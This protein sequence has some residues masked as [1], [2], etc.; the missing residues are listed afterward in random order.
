MARVSVIIPVYNGAATI[1]D[2]I[3]SVL[4]QNYGDFELIVADDGS[5]DTTAEVLER[6]AGAI[7]LITRPNGGISA[8]R[9]SG[10]RAAAGEY[11]ALL[12]CDDVWMPAMLERTVAALDANPGCVLAYTDLA[13]TD[14]D[15]RALNTAL[16]GPATAHAPTFDELFTHLWPIMP[17]AVV[18][19][20]RVLEMIGGFAEEFRSYGYEDVWCWMR[21][22]ELGDFC[23]VPERLVKWRFSSFPRP[24]K[25][26]TYNPVARAQFARMVDER[27]GRS[28][29]PLLRS[30]RRA[31]RSLL[32]Y[33]GL[34]EMR[35]GHPRRAREAFRSAL[36]LDP[37]RLKNYL[38]LL[39]TWLPNRIARRL[40]G[41]TAQTPRPDTMAHE[42]ED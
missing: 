36:R 33:I 25:N 28:V 6:Y 9:N 17:S 21:A 40:A 41:R 34:T 18:I 39:R 37:W 15:G 20:R 3:D 38:R 13:V 29:E 27:W 31:S 26:F 7:K 32:G 19:R 22:R 11:V 1:A 30:R 16:V 5:T 23:Y 35:K 12:D 10:L 2:T 8:A 24:L 42:L 14:S 4:A